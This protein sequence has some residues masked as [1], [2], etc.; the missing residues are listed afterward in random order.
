MIWQIFNQK[1]LLGN[2]NQRE[3]VVEIVCI[4]LLPLGAVHNISPSFYLKM[5]F[6]ILFLYHAHDFHPHSMSTYSMSSNIHI[7]IA[8]QQQY[9]AE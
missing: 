5:I 2:E 1:A 8:L 9:T 3:I 4:P 6:D 7:N